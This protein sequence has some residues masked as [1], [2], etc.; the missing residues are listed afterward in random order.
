MSRAAFQ[1]NDEV[2]AIDGKLVGLSNFVGYTIN[3]RAFLSDAFVQEDHAE[4]GTE[5]TVTWGEPDGGT[6]K[7]QVE[8][9]RQLSVRAT[10]APASYASAV[11]ELKNARLSRP[12]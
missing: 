9:Q 11:R 7:P 6:R 5:V 4:P 2:R 10:V 1:M 8:R 3:E 12:H